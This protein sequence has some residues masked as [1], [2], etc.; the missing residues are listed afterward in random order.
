MLTYQI[1][2]IRCLSLYPANVSLWVELGKTKEQYQVEKRNQ[3][4]LPS[5]P[6]NK[7]PFRHMHEINSLNQ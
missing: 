7:L 4:E 6:A 2:H 3:T 5:L 1:A